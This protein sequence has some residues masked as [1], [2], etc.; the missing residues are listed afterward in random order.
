MNQ[1]HRSAGGAIELLIPVGFHGKEEVETRR[2]HT[3]YADRLIRSDVL[4]VEGRLFRLKE[5]AVILVH[6]A[7]MLIVVG[8]FF[9]QQQIRVLRKRDRPQGRGFQGERLREKMLSE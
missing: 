4:E 2:K 1:P 8:Y 9:M 5:R 6:L 7:K 3:G